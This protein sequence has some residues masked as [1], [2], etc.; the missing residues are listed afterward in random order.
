W[1]SFTEL[2]DALSICKPRAYTSN[3]EVINDVSTGRYALGY[4]VLASFALRAVRE[5]PALTIAK[6]NVPSIAISRIAV[7]PKSAPHPDSAK[8]FLDYLL[9]RDGQQGLQDA[10]LFPIMDTKARAGDA[11]AVEPIPIA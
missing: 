2:T 6:T 10:G 4:H 11:N 7:I 9:S 1:T 8:L 3:P 5:N